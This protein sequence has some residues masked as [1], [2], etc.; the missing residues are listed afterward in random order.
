MLLQ[1][2]QLLTFISAQKSFA[3]W[4]CYINTLCKIVADLNSLSFRRFFGTQKSK[5]N[6][7]KYTLFKVFHT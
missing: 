5:Q 3:Q 1:S 4:K 6:N 7:Q 2:M